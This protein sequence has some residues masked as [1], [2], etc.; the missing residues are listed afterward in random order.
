MQI[1]RDGT[2]IAYR[3]GTSGDELKKLVV[4][5]SP[6]GYASNCSA[7]LSPD[8]SKLLENV[9]GHT[10]LRVFNWTGGS[11]TLNAGTI[12]HWDNQSF[13]VNSDEWICALDDDPTTNDDKGNGVGVVSM[14]N[15]AYQVCNF[16][17]YTMYPRFFVG[18]LPGQVQYALTVTNGSGDGSYSAGTSVPISADPPASG[19]EFDRWT[20]DVANVAN[21]NLASTTITMPAQA[22]TVTATYKDRDMTEYTLTVNRGSGDGAYLS[23]TQVQ[24]QAEAASGDS[25]F[26]RWTGSV[27]NVAS[28]TSAQT[29]ITMPAA[30]TTI[31][32]TYRLPAATTAITFPNTS[33]ELQEGSTVT[34]TADGTNVTWSYDAN[35]DGLGSVN[36]GTGNSVQFEVPTGV[37]GPRTITFTASGDNG[38]DQVTASIVEASVA[39]RAA[40]VDRAAGSLAAGPNPCRGTYT[41]TFT[42]VG[43]QHVALSIFDM[44]GK[45]VAV[46]T[47]AVLGAGR[48][49]LVWDGRDRTGRRVVNGAYTAALTI[50]GNRRSLRVVMAH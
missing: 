14:S 5:G 19:K 39:T 36:I 25:V 21:V 10:Q 1:S 3:A 50:G 28:V 12:G 48:H 33:S 11:I 38:T 43:E 40:V 31:S 29:T 18:N 45:R 9:G 30:N 26:D 8:G 17:G 7:G 27:A 13:A 47:D 16:S 22:T 34:L 35:S 41:V 44:T 46:V 6:V 42:A 49:S 4:G 23:G 2:R 37:T 24:I 32:A 15:D 20:G